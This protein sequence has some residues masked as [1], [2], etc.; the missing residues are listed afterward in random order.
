MRNV[1]IVGS[2][3]WVNTWAIQYPSKTTGQIKEYRVSISDMGTWGCSCAAWKFKRLQCDHINYVLS[4]SERKRKNK[5]KD[6]E[7]ITSPNIAPKEGDFFT[8]KRGRMV[9]L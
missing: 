3:R 2:T 5:T 4:K 9:L 7:D 6:I 1:Q 8:R